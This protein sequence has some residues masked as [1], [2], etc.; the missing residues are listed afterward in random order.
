MLRPRPCSER[1]TG[2]RRVMG[3]GFRK[4]RGRAHLAAGLERVEPPEQCG[5]ERRQLGVAGVE[6]LQEVV[7]AP[8]R[9][10]G[11]RQLALVAGATLLLPRCRWRA[12]ALHH[13]SGESGEG[14]VV[15]AV[16]LAIRVHSSLPLLLQLTRDPHA[17]ATR[18]W[19]GCVR[20]CTSAAVSGGC[21]RLM[22]VL[23]RRRGRLQQLR[24]NGQRKDQRAASEGPAR[25]AVAHRAGS[26]WADSGCRRRR[27][28]PAGASLLV[29]AAA[30]ARLLLFF[31]RGG[32]RYQVPILYCITYCTVNTIILS[33]VIG[34]VPG[35]EN[36]R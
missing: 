10:A 2:K 31:L 34:S 30:A 9:V 3:G 17:A 15:S 29:L 8:C 23:Y 4:W 20:G 18:R 21:C 22:E 12:A 28:Q 36:C 33:L 25:V 35:L 1:R 5:R 13:L 7:R 27:R 11:C 14:G 32:I 16:G 26:G 19:G 24:A 6:E